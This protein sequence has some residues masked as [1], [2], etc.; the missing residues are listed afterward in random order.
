MAVT[1]AANAI[2]GSTI[3][4]SELDE[5]QK[6]YKSEREKRLLTD[7]R[8][9]FL[10][11]ETVDKFAKAIHN[12]WPDPVYDN[13]KPTLGDGSRC[14]FQFVG[15]G[16]GSLTSAV[17]LLDAGVA[18]E[19]IRFVD[20]A[21]G[22]GGTW[23]LNRYPGLMCDVESYMYM[24][25][26][27]ET[28]YMPKRKYLYGPKLRE[29]AER[30][31]KKW[32]LFENGLFRVKAM[33]MTF[34][35]DKGEW[36]TK[37]ESPRAGE[38]SKQTTV[39]SRFAFINTEVLNWPKIPRVPG[40]NS[41]KGHVFHTSVWDY[42]YTGG[43]ERDPRPT[44]LRD[45]KV[46]IVG[47]GATAIQ[48]V[49]HLAEW[50]KELYV[51]QRT[52]SAVDTR[53]QRE[54]DP[55]WWKEYASKPGWQRERRLNHGKFNHN[56]YPRPAVDLV[57]D[58]WSTVPSYSGLIGSPNAPKSPEEIPPYLEKLQKMD[59]ILQKRVHACVDEI[60]KDKATAESLKAWYP[61]WCKHPCFHDD[62]LPSFNQ[63]N[64]TLV[65]TDGKGIEGLTEK[66]IVA[67]GKEY[68]LDVIIWSTGYEIFL[69]D[70]PGK[71]A[72]IKV[73]GRNGR[74]LDEKWDEKISTLY[75][76][77]TNGFPTCFGWV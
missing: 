48:V 72:R 67:L 55:E 65:D 18:P 23:W 2:D 70:S 14:E 50:A 35:E 59:L 75:G 52:A 22:F 60:I 19:D 49:P 69:P 64:V 24:P 56:E 42:E 44:N 16:Y 74:S 8:A 71:K 4:P 21:G 5:I 76:V 54:T 3:R 13:M 61:G 17:R 68:D 30:V 43:S 36:V 10:D 26:V 77:Q 66:G 45:K 9:Q 1:K 7:G 6:R 73:T 63:E 34:D 39:R 27:E 32:G 58:Q 38:E 29:Q 57:D 41:Y 28:G 31:A 12:A 37:L 62:Y 15:A 25:L 20:T 40:V 33:S 53:G 11:H 47:T 46:G 51:F